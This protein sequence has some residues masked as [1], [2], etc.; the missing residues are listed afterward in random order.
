MKEASQY[1]VDR[2]IPS[3]E[4]NKRGQYSTNLSEDPDVENGTFNLEDPSEK[5][6]VTD[7]GVPVSQDY[8][9]MD[10]GENYAVVEMEGET[11]LLEG[12]LTAEGDTQVEIIDND[13]VCSQN[14]RFKSPEQV[15]LESYEDSSLSDREVVDRVMEKSSLT[16]DSELEKLIQ[17]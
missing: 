5:E 4:N 13:T 6:L 14:S 1:E 12:D 16:T 7:G 2:A 17:F 10:S 15:R 3:L 9:V 11:Y 8:D